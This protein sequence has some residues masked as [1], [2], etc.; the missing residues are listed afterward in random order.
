MSIQTAQEFIDHVRKNE[1]LRLEIE[2]LGQDTAA[3]IALAKRE[4]YDITESEFAAVVR[5]HGYEMESELS[6]AELASVSGGTLGDQTI[7]CT[8]C[9]DCGTCWPDC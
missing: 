2:G 4:G 8:N 7:S 6:D 9:V 1:D 5:E 3:L